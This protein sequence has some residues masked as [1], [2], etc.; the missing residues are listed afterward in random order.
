MGIFVRA[1]TPKKI[2]DRI[3]DEVNKTLRAPSS[4]KRLPGT[5][6][7]VLIGDAW[8]T[9]VPGAGGAYPD[10]GTPG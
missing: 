3:N 9:W 6:L 8:R 10:H 4:S 1:G 7:R 2:V 5:R